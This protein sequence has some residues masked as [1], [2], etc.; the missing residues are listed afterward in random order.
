MPE[1]RTPTPVEEERKV[2]RRIM[3]LVLDPESQRPWSEEE[4]GREFDCDVTGSLAR[5]Y[6]AGLIHRLGGP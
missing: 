5:L 3:L 2:D 4:I 1:E 6:A